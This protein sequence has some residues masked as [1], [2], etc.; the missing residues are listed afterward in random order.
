MERSTP[1]G[2]RCA[3]ERAIV[4]SRMSAARSI[5]FRRKVFRLFRLCSGSNVNVTGNH[6][7]LLSTL[8]TTTSPI[9]NEIFGARILR[10]VPASARVGRAGER[11]LAITSFSLKAEPPP[12][13]NNTFLSEGSNLDKDCFGAT[14]KPTRE[15]RALP[16]PKNFASGEEYLSV[17][18]DFAA[19]R[20][21]GKRARAGVRVAMLQPRKLSATWGW[22][23]VEALN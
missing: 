20:C 11:V 14:P 9:A 8:R 12:G 19:V 13:F 23:N 2:M 3:P 16:N 5:T 22:D 1:S 7:S 21:T 10:G 4:Q 18:D 15:T 17:A 6:T